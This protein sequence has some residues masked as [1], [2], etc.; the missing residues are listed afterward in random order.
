MHLIM[1]ARAGTDV[2]AF[3][4][5]ARDFLAEQFSR[6]HRYAFALHDPTPLP[7]SEM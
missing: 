5:A 1:S 4:E 2:D 6:G 7:G 3:R